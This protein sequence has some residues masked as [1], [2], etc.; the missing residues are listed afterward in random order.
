MKRRC[1]ARKRR[2]IKRDKN[3]DLVAMPPY[4]R[5]WALPGSTRCRLHGGLSTGPRAPEGKAASTEARV[6]GRRQWVQPV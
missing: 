2:A 4:C 3:G 1:G 5:N 6:E